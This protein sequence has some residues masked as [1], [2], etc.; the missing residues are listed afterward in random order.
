MLPRSLSASSLTLVLSCLLLKN[1]NCIMKVHLPSHFCGN[2]CIIF[3]FDVTPF[4]QLCEV[5]E[6]HKVKYK[7]RLR[8]CV[9]VALKMTIKYA[10]LRLRRNDLST[11]SAMFYASIE[12][13][14]NRRRT[15][16]CL[17]I[18]PRLR[19]RRSSELAYVASTSAQRHC[20]AK[21]LLLKP[22]HQP[23]FII[24]IITSTGT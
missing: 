10:T 3:N 17:K 19:V 8:C 12:R 6:C 2:L 1:P 15:F 18:F 22:T 4:Y 9:D 16:L 21:A 20:S 24:I 11:C 7:V 5:T 23:R 13:E 14:E